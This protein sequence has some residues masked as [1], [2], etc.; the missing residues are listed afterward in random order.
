MSISPL[1][2]LR[3]AQRTQ[4]R[5]GAARAY[6]VVA[7]AT[8]A[9]GSAVLR[10][11]IGGQNH[12]VVHVLA[13]EAITA[14]LRGLAVTVVPPVPAAIAHVA[15]N[16]A[17]DPPDDPV[18]DPASDPFAA[19]PC[20][21]ADIGIVMFEAPR[22]HHERERAL[23][24]PQPA[25]LAPLARWMQRGG[26]HTLAVVM[27]HAQ[28]QLPEAL[29][30]GLANLDEQAV[31]ALGLERLII[32]RSAQKPAT[33]PAG[34]PWLPRVAQFMLGVFKYMVPGAEQPVRADKVAALVQCALD[35]APPGIHIAAPEVVWQ[36]AQGDLPG[37]AARWLQA[38][39]VP[40]PRQEP[41]HSTAQSSP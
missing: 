11:L 31:A 29:K 14:G 28:G 18:V 40:A 8:G 15:A 26:V 20:V 12:A 9:L 2:A 1:Q 22:D 33:L 24:T 38:G 10:R 36:A 16:P 41:A 35:I 19:W 13:R 21:A 34:G 5:P 25:Q 27:P 17:A 39:T 23:W 6:I 4:P 37:V 30:R 3:A 32:V 7:G